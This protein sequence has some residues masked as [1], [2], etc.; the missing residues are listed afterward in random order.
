MEE[1]QR[2][3]PDYYQGKDGYFWPSYR[4]LARA[5]RAI[6]PSQE[7]FIVD[8]DGNCLS[9]AIVA[10]GLT[11]YKTYTAL[12]RAAFDYVCAD[13]LSVL[14]T[15]KDIVGIDSL[16]GIYKHLQTDGHEGGEEHIAMFAL[17]LGKQIKVWDAFTAEE[18]QTFC[19]PGCADHILE[20]P[21]QLSYRP[22]GVP[23]YNSARSRVTDTS[24]HYDAVRTVPP[25]SQPGNRSPSVPG[26]R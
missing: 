7:I 2:I 10:S 25:V 3:L 13:E 26:R 17:F 14:S 20:D 8:G 15:L 24:G 19:P 16:E 18:I 12:K 6:R 5:I 23:I 9:R 4:R 22:S 21:I 11:R 1:W